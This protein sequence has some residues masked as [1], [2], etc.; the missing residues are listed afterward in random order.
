VTMLWCNHAQASLTTLQWASRGGA[1]SLSVRDVT[2]QRDTCVGVFDLWR[3][4]YTKQ[5]ASVDVSAVAAARANAVRVDGLCTVSVC[6]CQWVM[7]AV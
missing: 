2:A 6:A 4:L 1:K 7:C 3:A 5:R